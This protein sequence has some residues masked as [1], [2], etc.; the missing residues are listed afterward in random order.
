[1][2]VLYRNQQNNSVFIMAPGTKLN[3]HKHIADIHA[4][5][6]QNRMNRTY[7]CPQPSSVTQSVGFDLYT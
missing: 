1:M 2:N 3:K 4:D 6:D 5:S 7:N